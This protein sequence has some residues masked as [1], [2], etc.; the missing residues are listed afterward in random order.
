M[1]FLD[2][3]GIDESVDRGPFWS[4]FA[5]FGGQLERMILVNIAWALQFAPAI[6]AMMLINAPT[7][8]RLILVLYTAIVIPPAT[9]TLYGLMHAATQ[10]ESLDVGL[11]RE[12]FGEL[13]LASYKS[14]APLL[15]LLG[16]VLWSISLTGHIF[17]VSVLLQVLL[18]LLVVSANYWGGIF[19]SSPALSAYG[20][21]L[22]AV[23]IVWQYP[24]RSLLLTLMVLLAVVLGAISV[25]G[26]ALAVPV[27]ITL[28]QAQM[29]ETI[30]NE[31]TN[32]L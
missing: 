27:I 4:A 6:F 20:I 14:F 26:L 1:P 3:S 15:G 11:A 12:I 16:F 10:Y 2:D 9:A 25:G 29:L 32:N 23:Q 8:L 24:T 31:T 30:F 17:I 19:V 7:P 5:L 13:W 22:K 18:L 28:L 21:F